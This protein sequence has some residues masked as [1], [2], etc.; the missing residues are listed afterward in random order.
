MITAAAHT[1]FALIKY[2]GKANE[3][4]NLPADGSISV[5]V[6][7]LI[8]RTS[9]KFDQNLKKDLITLNDTK[10]DQRD[11]KRIISY[12]DLIRGMAKERRFAEVGSLNNYPTAA[13]VRSDQTDI[14]V[15]KLIE[16]GEIKIWKAKELVND[17]NFTRRW[18]YRRQNDQAAAVA[19]PSLRYVPKKKKRSPRLLRAQDMRR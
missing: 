12:P 11:S 17:T 18:C 2:R 19:V 9:V 14:I 1:N 3:K 7:K 5:T 15:E 16:S 6:N 13:G 8:T 4:L 10:V